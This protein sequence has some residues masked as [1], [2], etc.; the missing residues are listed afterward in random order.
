MSAISAMC[1]VE[2]PLFCATLRKGHNYSCNACV[3]GEEAPDHRSLKMGHDTPL[4]SGGMRML[5]D[6]L[7]FSHLSRM[8][9]T[10]FATQITMQLCEEKLIAYLACRQVKGC[11]RRFM[12]A[13]LTYILYQK[14]MNCRVMRVLRSWPTFKHEVPVA[15][16]KFRGTYSPASVGLEAYTIFE[17]RDRRIDDLHVW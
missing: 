17:T 14:H 8:F 4:Q 7:S 1:C 6:T 3:A 16:V 9:S 5:T 10:G 13:R 2:S 12:S 15:V 11:I